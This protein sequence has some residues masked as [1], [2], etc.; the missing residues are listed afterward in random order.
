MGATVLATLAFGCTS[1][2]RRPPG[3]PPSPESVTLEEPGGDAHEPHAAALSRQLDEPWGWRNDKDDQVHFPLPDWE[4]WRRVRI[5]FVDHLTAFKYGD[6]RHLLSAA[7]VLK[8]PPEV[9]PSTETCMALFER[10]AR[11]K[12]DTYRVSFTPIRS[13]ETRWR[14]RPLAVHSTD[15]ELSF[16]FS[17]YEFSSAW[18]AYPAYSDGC[19]VYAVV[20]QWEDQPELARKVR[21]RWIAEGFEGVQTRTKMLPFRHED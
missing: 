11:K 7:F 19:L 12:A 6:D 2:A 10:E 9:T 8:T 3:L 14:G 17:H 16:L 21:D 18:A 5:R 4:H 15:G 20:V 1:P 13:H